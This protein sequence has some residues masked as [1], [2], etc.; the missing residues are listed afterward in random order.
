MWTGTET[1][2][3]ISRKFI[4]DFE[5]WPQLRTTGGY[6]FETTNSWI[7]LSGSWRSLVITAEKHLSGRSGKQPCLETIEKVLANELPPRGLKIHH[8]G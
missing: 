3:F 5:P 8:E 6:F 4:L 1:Q 2:S 7:A